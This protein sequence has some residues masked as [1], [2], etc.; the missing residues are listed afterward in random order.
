MAV[1]T[2]VERRGFVGGLVLFVL[3]SAG[4]LSFDDALQADAPV[5]KRTKPAVQQTAASPQEEE[6]EKAMDAA[7]E[8]L[9]KFLAVLKAPKKTQEQFAVKFVVEVKDEAELLWMNE[10]KFEKGVF[11]GKLANVPALAKHLK[12]GDVV[13]VKEDDVVDWM[14]VEDGK[15]QGGYTIRAQRKFIQATDRK[16]FDDQFKF[17]FE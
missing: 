3:G 16:K 6:M 17:K 4:W 14:Y 8:N 9:D 5:R 7:V 13:K 2:K 11:T 15:L 10:P 12:A 1:M